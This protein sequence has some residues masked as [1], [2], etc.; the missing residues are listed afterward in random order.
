MRYATIPI[1]GFTLGIF[2]AS[3][4]YPVSG[5][6]TEDGGAVICVK[7]EPPPDAGAQQGAGPTMVYVPVHAPAGTVTPQR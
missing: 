1:L 2:I 5:Q 7:I 6:P 4:I 3:C